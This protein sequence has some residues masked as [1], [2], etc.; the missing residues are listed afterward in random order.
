MGSITD[1][2]R[3]GKARRQ[4]V[5]AEAVATFQMVDTGTKRMMGEEG[6]GM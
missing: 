4:A 6:K 1:T 2:A 5:A 3:M